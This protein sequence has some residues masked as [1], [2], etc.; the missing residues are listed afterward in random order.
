MCVRAGEF[1]QRV[2]QVRVGDGANIGRTRRDELR[3]QLALLARLADAEDSPFATARSAGKVAHLQAVT[4]AEPAP[5]GRLRGARIREVAVLLLASSPNPRRPIHYL[6]WYELLRSA[7]YGVDARDPAAAFLTQINRSP[8]VRR[9]GAPGVYALDFEAPAGLRERLQRLEAQL[10]A[11]TAGEGSAD[12]LAA[13]RNRRAALM[14]SVRAAER[15]LE[16]SLRA[17][18]ATSR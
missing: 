17:F 15:E 6:Q 1:S 9:A 2:R 18:A 12:D 10:A 14:S 4:S 16:E 11:E 7:G 13:S 5:K 3:D 8:V